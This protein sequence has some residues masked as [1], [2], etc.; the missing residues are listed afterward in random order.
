[1]QI[2]RQQLPSNDFLPRALFLKQHR[3]NGKVKQWMQDIRVPSP[4]SCEAQKV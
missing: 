3:Q 2:S 4:T 1:M